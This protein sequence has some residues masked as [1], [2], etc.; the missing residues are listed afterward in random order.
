MGDRFPQGSGPNGE[1]EKSLMINS[2]AQLWIY[3]KHGTRPTA[4]RTPVYGILAVG[5]MV[6]FLYRDATQTIRPW[7][8]GNGLA[9][10]HD[11]RQYY[12]LE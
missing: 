12:L 4:Q 2:A 3:L 8:P 1:Q 9:L 5:R 7:R 10:G 11:D 6:R